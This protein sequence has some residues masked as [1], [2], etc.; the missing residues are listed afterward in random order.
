MKRVSEINET[1]KFNNTKVGGMKEIMI[2][3]HA[4]TRLTRLPKETY[5]RH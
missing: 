1:I 3:A 2:K 4:L 5:A